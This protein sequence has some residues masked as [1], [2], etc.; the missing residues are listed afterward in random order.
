[1]LL[2]AGFVVN[3]LKDAGEFKKIEPHFNG[4][5][6]KISG[7]VGG[8]DI[9]IDHEKRIAYI[10]AD[11]RFATLNGRKGLGG[12][13]AL[14]LDS[15]ARSPILV[16]RTP[17]NEIHPHG[18][19]YFKTPGGQAY[20]YAVDHTGGR[21]SILL[22]QFLDDTTL[23][24]LRT[25]ADSPLIISP[26]DVAAV[27]EH[28]FFFTNDHGSHSKLGKTF[29]EYLQLAKSNVVYFD[30]KEF[31]IAAEKL[32]YANGINISRDRRELYVAACIGKRI[33]VYDHEISSGKLSFKK[34]INLNT[35]VDNIELDESG[36]LWVACHPQLLTFVKHAKDTSRLAPSQV[37]KIK[38]ESNGNFIL[39]EIYL[40]QGEEISASSVAAVAGNTLLI[41]AVLDN[42]ILRC[43]LR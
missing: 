37:I 7:I 21:H 38:K 36:N 20:L 15:P 13:Y 39:E 1:M 24:L 4:S 16:K 25:F 40:N 26:N 43:E 22:F 33:L 8:E 35:G 6:S 17:E 32:A 42:H 2:I 14:Y 3:T 12:F 41:G 27:D 5:V 29:E 10:S 19:S 9:T 34:E 23:S 18:I 28:R 31:S 11:D 30:G